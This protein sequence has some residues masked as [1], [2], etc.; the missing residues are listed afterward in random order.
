MADGSFL[1]ARIIFDSL[2]PQNKRQWREREREWHQRDKGRSL[3]ILDGPSL[4]TF[5][6]QI[7]LNLQ[8]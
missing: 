4:A 8:S 6:F 1:V 5:I 3:E 2:I 7:N